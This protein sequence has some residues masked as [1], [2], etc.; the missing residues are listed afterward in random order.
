[1][2][3]AAPSPH[4]ALQ[5]E[6]PEPG[7]SPVPT[8]AG[9]AARARPR[10][11][12]LQLLVDGAPVPVCVRST[13][14]ALTAA[15]RPRSWVWASGAA[16]SVSRTQ[17]YAGTRRAQEGPGC[18]P[19]RAEGQPELCLPPGP[20]RCGPGHPRARPAVRTVNSFANVRGDR[21]GLALPGAPFQRCAHSFHGASLSCEIMTV[22]STS[23]LRKSGLRGVGYGPG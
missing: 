6:H 11:A 7:L 13:R 14:V 10:L 1:M 16:L 9:R 15:W 21:E 17:G 4:A 3:K 2:E 18:P 22:T 8:P 20:S 5:A 12:W 19:A 23:Q